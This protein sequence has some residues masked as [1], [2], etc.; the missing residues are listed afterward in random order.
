MKNKNNLKG[1]INIGKAYGTSRKYIL[2]NKIE[3]K[4]E[5][6]VLENKLFIFFDWLFFII[7]L[8]IRSIF[9]VL[10]FDIILKIVK[11]IFKNFSEYNRIIDKSY[12]TDITGPNQMSIDEIEE[13]IKSNYINNIIIE[14]N[15]LINDLVIFKTYRDELN[16]IIENQNF[17]VNILAV[18]LAITAIAFS[19]GFNQESN[20]IVLAIIILIIT[21]II[22]VFWTY[23]YYRERK[24]SDFNKLKTINNVVYILEAI[25]DNL[26]EVPENFDVEVKHLNGEKAGKL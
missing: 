15:K 9:E 12:G 2:S 8:T 25:K 13:Y 5:I 16:L 24:K 19:S 17:F 26:D 20:G 18:I 23:M 6:F 7:Y 11:F 1:K 14:K 3:N 21:L 10:F 22:L 4:K